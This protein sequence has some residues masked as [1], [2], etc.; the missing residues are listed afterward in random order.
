MIIETDNTVFGCGADAM[1]NTVNCVGFMG[2]GL[3][4]EFALRYPN[5]EKAYIQDCKENK[6]HTG[7]VNVYRLDDV[8]IINFPTKFHFKYFSKME[9]VEQG[10]E[11]FLRIYKNLGIQSVAFPLLGA[12]NGGLDPNDVLALMKERLAKADITVY[13]CHSKN[14]DEL[15]RKMIDRF[16][17]AS[18]DSVATA[19]R[20]TSAQKE[21]LLAAKGHIA[22]FYE[23]REYPKIGDATYRALFAFFKEDYS[24]LSEMVQMRLF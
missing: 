15:E 23:I 16:N 17:S 20:L 2:K 8:T 22:H 1:V 19:V 10:L 12:S 6:V 4:L 21:S 7:K 14:P 13:I 11:D 18:I 9:W 24:G 5:L 3:A